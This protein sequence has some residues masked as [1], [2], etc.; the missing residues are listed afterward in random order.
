MSIRVFLYW[1][2]VDGRWYEL[3]LYG[4]IVHVACRQPDL[5]EIWNLDEGRM[6]LRKLRAFATGEEVHEECEYVGTAIEPTGDYAW[7]LFEDV[8]DK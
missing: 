6:K 7:H 4:K 2:P 3:P 5:V 1:I 8:S